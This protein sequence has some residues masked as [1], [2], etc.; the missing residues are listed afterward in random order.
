M[1]SPDVIALM[2][3]YLDGVMATD[4]KVA[5][6]V[7]DPRPAKLLQVRLVSQPKLPP[8]RRIAR[9]DVF[10]WGADVTDETGAMDLGR[11][12]RDAINALIGTTLLGGVEVYRVEETLGLRQFDDDKTG[13]PR[14]WATYAVTHRDESAIR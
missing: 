4:V 2:I 13:T 6:R 12:A 9:F 11:T 1:S 14:S 7:P 8:V 5:T 10:G 3:A